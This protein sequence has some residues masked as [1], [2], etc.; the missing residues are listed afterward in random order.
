[1][2]WEPEKEVW[3][4]DYL[5]Y[6]EPI[7]EDLYWQEDDATLIPKSQMIALQVLQV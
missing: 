6:M 5:I 3:L 2:G 4:R 7:I 1:M